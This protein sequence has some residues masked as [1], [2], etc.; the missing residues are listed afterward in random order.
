MN[1][2]LMFIPPVTCNNH[3]LP[4][5]LHPPPQKKK[6]KRKKEKKNKDPGFGF[7]VKIHVLESLKLN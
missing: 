6:K 7:F 5:H 4:L 1:A 3:P 2:A